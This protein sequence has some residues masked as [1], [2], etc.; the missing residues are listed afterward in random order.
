MISNVAIV[1]D[2]AL[3]LL[4]MDLKY[5]RQGLRED[6]KLV[7]GM[8]GEFFKALAHGLRKR[9]DTIEQDVGQLTRTVSDG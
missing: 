8:E 4:L 1:D 6:A 7:E 9:A 2:A 5:V 3:S